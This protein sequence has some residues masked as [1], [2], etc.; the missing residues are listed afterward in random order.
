MSNVIDIFFKLIEDIKSDCSFSDPLRSYNHP[1]NSCVHPLKSFG[2]TLKSFGHPLNSINNPRKGVERLRVIRDLINQYVLFEEVHAKKQSSDIMSSLASK[3]LRGHK[4]TDK[5]IKA[6]A[7][8][9][10]SQDENPGRRL[11]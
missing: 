10:L 5:E 6:L 8:S 4:P 3:V 7:A 9:V 11:A 2:H 1:L